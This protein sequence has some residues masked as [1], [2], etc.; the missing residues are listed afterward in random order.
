VTLSELEARDRR[1]AELDAIGRKRRTLAEQDEPAR[2]L[3]ARDHF[4]RRLPAALNRTRE[5]AAQLAAYARQHR[6]EV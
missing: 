1:I 6:L 5:K 2:L 3:A 4:W